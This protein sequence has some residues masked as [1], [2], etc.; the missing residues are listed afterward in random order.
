MNGSAVG[1]TILGA[2]LVAG[3]A[4]YRLEHFYWYDIEYEGTGTM[5]LTAA[6]GTVEDVT[7]IALQ[8]AE[9]SSSPLKFRAC[10]RVEDAL[11]DR[12][13]SFAPAPDAAPTVAPRP[14]DCFDADAIAQDLKDGA[15]TAVLGQTNTPYGI[16]RIVAITRNG[17][18]FAWHQI[19]R[20][21]E[22]VFDG[23]PPPEGCPPPPNTE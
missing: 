21:G 3:I 1:I 19:N 7:V 5:A 15:A 10:F 2:A 4:L 20:C 14:F 6:D 22:R 8:H 18:A 17:D 12:L 23:D 11:L 16:D 9:G 13:A